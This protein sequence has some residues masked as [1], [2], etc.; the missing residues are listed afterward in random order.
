MLLWPDDYGRLGKHTAAGSG[1]VSN[2]VLWQEANYFDVASDT[3]I[4]LHLWSL[5]I[6]EQFYLVWPA[7][8]WI[9]RRLRLNMFALFAAILVASLIYCIRTTPSNPMAAFYSPAARFWELA[10]GSVLA[11]LNFSNPRAA[12]LI[13]NTVATTVS[14]AL[15]FK[16][17]KIDR[18]ATYRNFLS[19][20]AM[21]VIFSSIF[22]IIG[23]D[24]FPGS[25][26]LLPVAGSYLAI[27]AGPNAW[28]N[29]LLLSSP[30]L[31]WIGLI[32][33][34]LYLWHWPPLVFARHYYGSQPTPALVRVALIAFAVCL[35]WL[36]YRYVERPIRFGTHRRWGSAGA[37]LRHGLY[38]APRRIDRCK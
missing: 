26:A 15:F 19:V 36:T 24:Q 7:L 16:Q 8:I 31:V 38:R 12:R 5:G 33:Y 27:L 10:A 14:S 18:E 2:L 4:L 22:M 37:W 6:E 3:K 1:F 29:R 35:A 34:P 20:V 11:Q 13:E 23:L 9:A 30:A 32:S 17:G 28:L 25:W 21:V